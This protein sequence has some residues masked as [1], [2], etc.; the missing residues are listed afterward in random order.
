MIIMLGNHYFTDK[1]VALL[2]STDLPGQL[3]PADAL[4][5]LIHRTQNK[6]VENIL[7]LLS[8]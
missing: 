8:V 2:D 6:V 3:E 7:A 1:D 4:T 5:S